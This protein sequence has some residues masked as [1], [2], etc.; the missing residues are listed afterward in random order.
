MK[1]PGLDLGGLNVADTVTDF[2]RVLRSIDSKLDTL[3]E[4]QRASISLPAVGD[5]AGTGPGKVSDDISPASPFPGHPEPA[6]P[7][8]AAHARVA[9]RLDAI[10]TGHDIGLT[11]AAEFFPQHTRTK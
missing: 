8:A 9:A 11:S 4:L 10:K 5:A 1:L 6:D 7:M 3:I 2:L